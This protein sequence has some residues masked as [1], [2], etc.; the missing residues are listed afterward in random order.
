ML[1]VKLGPEYRVIDKAATVHFKKLGKTTLYAEFRLNEQDIAEIVT[2]LKD[3]PKMDWVREISV[4]DSNQE[5][6]ATVTKVISIKKLPKDLT[7]RA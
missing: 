2:A 1:T 5:E 3:T 4:T 6:I 7:D